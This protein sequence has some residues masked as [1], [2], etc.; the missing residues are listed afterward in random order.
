MQN[1][2]YMCQLCLKD[3]LPVDM[4]SKPDK[5]NPTDENIPV[6][7]NSNHHRLEVDSLSPDL[8]KGCG[9][10]IECDNDCLTCDVC[11]NMQRV[12]SLCLS[13]KTYDTESLNQV[14]ESYV[15][16]KNIFIMH[17][18][19]RSLTLHH[20]KLETLLL[21]CEVHPDII[22]ISETRLNGDFN[23][24]IVQLPGYKFIYQHSVTGTS[25][26]GGVGMYMSKKLNYSLRPDLA[27]NFDGCETKFVEIISAH[28]SAQNTI[29]GVIYR[30]PHE[31]HIMFNASFGNILEKIANKY[32]IVMCG[33]INIDLAESQKSQTKE[34]KNLLLSFGCVHLINKYTRI[35]TD[36]NGSTSKTIIDHMITNL[37]PNQTKSVVLH[38]EI[39]DHLPIFSM[40]SLFPKRQRQE[41]QKKRVYNGKGKA[42]F[43]EAL[44]LSV[45]HMLNNLDYQTN[46]D[47][48][49][50]HLITEIQTIEERAFPVKTLSRKKSKAL[51]KSW[52]TPGILQ[53][54]KHRDKLFRDQLGKSDVNLI[55]TGEKE[56][57]LIGLLKKLRT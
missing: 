40:F 9:L 43:T 55:L 37:N 24:N 27:F 23:K 28:P 3:S 12:C 21:N 29:V 46:P 26:V 49:L 4:V 19:M 14:L 13:C 41:T 33:D 52:M 56:I 44:T 7:L 57:I 54:M 1:H 45:H 22:A 36:I 39:A 51:R 10:C 34:Y 30:H 50:K 6:L 8:E 42:K 20:E 11:P 53:S 47:N 32:S 35:F 18:N 25:D 48:C 2:T 31:N 15:K 17:I 16:E 38:Y 5:I